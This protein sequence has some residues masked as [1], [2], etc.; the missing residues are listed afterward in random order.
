MHIFFLLQ[1][2]IIYVY[3]NVNILLIYDLHIWFNLHGILKKFSP[4]QIDLT[5]HPNKAGSARSNNVP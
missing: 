3:K 4:K 2:N 5:C 1:R